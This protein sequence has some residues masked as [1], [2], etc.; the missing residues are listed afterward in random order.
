MND[1]ERKH[2]IKMCWL[3]IVSTEP[4]CTIDDGKHNPSWLHEGDQ[5]WYY[6]F[7]DSALILEGL[8]VPLTTRWILC[9]KHTYL[10]QETAATEDR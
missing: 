7:Q 2:I 1:S 9:P 6:D 4:R 3:T 5:Y 8:V 10:A